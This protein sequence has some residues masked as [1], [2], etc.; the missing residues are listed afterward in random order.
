MQGQPQVTDVDVGAVIQELQNAKAAIAQLQEEH[1]KLKVEILHTPKL[2]YRGHSS[3]SSSSSSSSSST[4]SSSLDINQLISLMAR[5]P[6]PPPDRWE[7]VMGQ[8]I[9]RWLDALETQHNYYHRSEGDKILA[10]IA[11]LHGP[12]LSEWRASVKA[13]GEP[14]SYQDLCDRLTKRWSPILGSH[15]VRQELNS[16]VRRGVAKMSDVPRYIAQFRTLASKLDK[17]SAESLIFS[18]VEGLPTNLKLAVMSKDPVDLDAAIVVA[19][20]NAYSQVSFGGNVFAPKASSPNLDIVSGSSSCDMDLSAIEA[21]PGY[22]GLSEQD[23]RVARD[24]WASE[25]FGS[26]DTSSSSSSSSSSTPNMT[27]LLHRQ[28]MDLN[29]KMEDLNAVRMSGGGRS[30]NK[31]GKG[32]K[33][34]KDT[35][36]KEDMSQITPATIRDRKARGKC[37]RCDMANYEKGGHTSRNCTNPLNT[38]NLKL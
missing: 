1:Q 14:Q 8:G 20:K 12:A 4:S 2:V 11:L 9:N 26:F 38:K 22:H 24:V 36:Y 13:Q 18:F 17:D 10:T 5:A 31:G 28:M 23:R 37:I 19:S 30:S 6:L 16:L 27:M 25:G 15:Q 7:G 35:K 29:K 34:A 33:D 32:A 3:A 21:Y